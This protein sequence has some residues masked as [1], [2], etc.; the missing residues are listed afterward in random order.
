LT[1][2]MRENAA[3]LDAIVEALRPVDLYI[4]GHRPSDSRRRNFWWRISGGL[5]YG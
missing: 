2:C 3:L 4:T 5:L 1:G